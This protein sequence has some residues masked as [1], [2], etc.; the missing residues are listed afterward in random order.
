MVS[1]ELAAVLAPFYKVK[2][3]EEVINKIADNAES[4]YAATK[5]AAGAGPERGLMPQTAADGKTKETAKV[6]AIKK[7]AINWNPKA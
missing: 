6:A 1:E 5:K 7:G 2:T 4:L 3:R